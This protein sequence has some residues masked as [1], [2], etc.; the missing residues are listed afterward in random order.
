M[1][2][3]CRPISDPSNR[4][5]FQPLAVPAWAFAHKS[6]QDRW[7]HHLPCDGRLTFTTCTSSCNKLRQ[8]YGMHIKPSQK[9]KFWVACAVCLCPVCVVHI[10]YVCSRNMRKIMFW[11]CMEM[12]TNYMV[13]CESRIGMEN[14]RLS[15]SRE[16]WLSLGKWVNAVAASSQLVRW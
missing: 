12:N 2:L 15:L 3:P 8:N 1:V 9:R 10:Q 5:L 11:K 6:Q 13:V 7:E 4:L 16:L 14:H